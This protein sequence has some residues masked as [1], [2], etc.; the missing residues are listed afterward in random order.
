MRCEPVAGGVFFARGTDVNWVIVRDGTSLTLIDTGYPA[1]VAAVEESIREIGSQPEDVVAI[2]LTHAHIDHIGAVN[3]LHETYGTPVYVHPLEV[4]HAHRQY[5]EQAGRLDVARHAW[6]PAVLAWSMR[7]VRAGAT[8]HLAVP[9]AQAFASAGALELPGRPVPIAMHGHTSGHSAFHFPDAGVIVTG[10][11]LV[12]AHPTSSTQGPQLLAPWF[13][14]SSADAAA[15]LDNLEP[16]DADLLL[17]GHGG[18]W[19]G[20]VRDAVRMARE[21]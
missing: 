11:G 1:D 5:L 19:R 10:D 17:P 20:A 4:A 9:S 3:H 21:R 8:Q 6:R 2:L 15:A 13:D 18:L 14:H 7:I 16:L 12:T